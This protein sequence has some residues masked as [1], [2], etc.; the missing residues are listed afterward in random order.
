[1]I[2]DRR[3]ALGAL[4]GLGAMA[5]GGCSNTG[6]ETAL[7]TDDGPVVRGISYIGVS[8]SDIDRTA[9]YFTGAGGLIEVDRSGLRGG[10]LD[11]IAGKSVSAKT[12]TLR[13][14]S[15][16]IRLMQFDQP[17]AAAR[18][19]GVVPVQG[20]GIT[21]V[22]FQSPDSK[23]IFSKFVAAG[24]KPLSR[25]GDLVQLRPDVPVKYAYL[26]DADGT[27]IEIEQ[28]LLDNLTFDY[29]MRHVAIA[30]LNID[31]AVA[32]YTA[33]LGKAPRE[34]RSNLVNKTLDITANLEDMKLDVAWFQ[35][36]NLELEIWEYLNPAPTPATEVRPL[37][38]LGH[39][40]IVFD[41]SD[42]AVALQK[43]QDAGGLRVAAPSA[44]DG[45]QIA[46]GRDPDG[47]LIG[48]FR[49]GSDAS[50]FST[51]GLVY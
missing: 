51:R 45:G 10:V 15:G 28:L 43:L 20:P 23:P 25:T 24:A 3:S 17:A 13:S 6:A 32:F 30:S 49:P 1:M 21:H 37:E 38:A 50:P 19:A 12:R 9:A 7:Q 4:I 33:V 8:V 29:R 46:F 42:P 18:A 26:R 2:F 31:R 48:F 5:Y 47:N 27:M 36:S 14:N 41:V 35:L 34:R 44:M 11:R 40:M 39:N 16:Q 22:C